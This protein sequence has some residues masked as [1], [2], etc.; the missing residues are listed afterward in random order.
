MRCYTNVQ[1]SAVS[2]VT[3]RFHP[4]AMR[5]LAF[6]HQPCR[7]DMAFHIGTSLTLPYFSAWLSTPFVAGFRGI[8]MSQKWTFA[9]FKLWFRFFFFTVKN[10][11][12]NVLGPTLTLLTPTAQSIWQILATE[13]TQYKNSSLWFLTLQKW[14]RNTWSA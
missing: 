8:H 10:G 7:L 14:K 6:T 2:S 11:F 9:W 1:S 5:R 13:D 4:P 3:P 12:K